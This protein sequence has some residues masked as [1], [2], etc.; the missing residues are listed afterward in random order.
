LPSLQAV[1]LLATCVQPVLGAQL[2][3]VHGL[4]SSQFGAPAPRHAPFLQVSFSVQASPSE[5][6]VPFFISEC[7]QR[8]LATSHESVV[9]GLPSSQL[10]PALLTH[11]PP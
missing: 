5:H 11:L 9:Q 8:C 6:A 4:R 1:P 7:A 3:A 10:S 2:S